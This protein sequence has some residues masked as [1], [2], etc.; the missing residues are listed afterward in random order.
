VSVLQAS[1]ACF[2]SFAC[3][4]FEN[5]PGLLQQGLDVGNTGAITE[6]MGVE[7]DVAVEGRRR[8][9]R[10]RRRRA[11]T[12]YMC[13]GAGQVCKPGCW[14][15]AHGCWGDC[16]YYSDGKVNTS[17]PV[18]C[19]CSCGAGTPEEVLHQEYG[20]KDSTQC[21]E[22]LKNTFAMQGPSGNM[23]TLQEGKAAAG[24]PSQTLV[25]APAYD[26]NNDPVHQLC[27]TIVASPTWTPLPTP[28]PAP[29]P[30]PPASPPRRRAPPPNGLYKCWSL[31]PKMFI[32]GLAKKLKSVDIEI[33]WCDGL[34]PLGNGFGTFIGALV[35]S[36]AS[37][38]SVEGGIKW[39]L[40]QDPPH[41]STFWHPTKW[42]THWDGLV[43]ICYTLGFLPFDKPRKLKIPGKGEYGVNLKFYLKGCFTVS[44]GPQG[45]L[46]IEINAGAGV[47]AMIETVGGITGDGLATGYV[48]LFD[49]SF[50]FGYTRNEFHARYDVK[51]IILGHEFCSYRGNISDTAVWNGIAEYIN[52]A[53]QAV[54]R[55][56]QVIADEM[57]GPRRRRRAKCGFGC[58]VQRWLPR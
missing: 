43:R 47:T 33:S 25:A 1:F 2:L 9:R 36:G 37:P 3:Y 24:I 34:G 20:F 42:K 5:D 12:R 8:R 40:D 13:N 39:P 57:T 48:T 15:Q 52:Q 38:W 4:L 16:N 17:S 23:V 22:Y 19:G 26:P 27:T 28:S 56:D 35:S 18:W 29:G 21:G 49:Y 55:P 53:V 32:P 6:T 46:T 54:T 7:T 45:H 58:K 30:L 11:K 44:I 14:S 51:L 41:G 10:R 50:P 31:D